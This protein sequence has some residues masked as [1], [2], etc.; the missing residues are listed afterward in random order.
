MQ[1][2]W[3]FK[4]KPTNQQVQLMSSW[5]ITLRKHRNFML[6]ERN[7]GYE[8]NNQDND[9]PIDY[10]WGGYCAVET[11]IEYFSWCPLTCPVLKHG[12][13]PQDL[14][15]ALKKQKDKIV[16]DN[17]SGIQSKITTQLRKTN[18]WFSVL[19]SNVLQ[20]NIAKLDTAFS[21]F[22]KKETGYPNFKPRLDSFEYK[23]KQVKLRRF[24]SSYGYFYLPGI[25]E[26]KFH[27]SRDL[28]EIQQIRT[29]TVTR[30]GGYWFISLLVEIPDTL[31]ETKNLEDVKSVI[32]IDVGV[33]KLVSS[34]DGK[35]FENKRFTTNKRTARRLAIRDRS[36]SRKKDGSNNKR[37][38]Y[39]TLAKQKHKL[40]TKR[41]GYNWQVANEIVNTADLV[42][43]EDL[44]IQGMVKRAKPKHDGKG[45]YKQN[46]AQAKSGLN[47][48]ILDC[49]WSQIFN[50]IAWLALKAGKP[51][52]EVNP[53][54]SSQVC[55]KCGH[56]DKANRKGEK[57]ICLA[58]GFVDHADTKAARE[59]AKRVGL[60][61]PKKIL[62][63]DCGK[64]TSGIPQEEISSR[65]TKKS[66]VEPGNQTTERYIQL[67]LFE[68]FDNIAK[69][70][71]LEN[72]SDVSKESPPL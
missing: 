30:S 66:S 70:G 36:A 13:I 6:N 22:F 15:K 25:G 45:G 64:V 27:N 16:W 3:N 21:K 1:I 26:V 34:S 48:V 32:G 4:L 71:Y 52:I 11:K 55:P 61:F 44:N 38:A 56:T 53:R 5:L 37:K 29:T 41:D 19:D 42:A 51:V 2:R 54:F 40:A 46:G 43:R 10:D 67:N 24:S 39:E 20:R 60:I 65:W 58:C 50:K 17:A 14:S 63:A 57:F 47:K 23:P 49:A 12:V 72:C 69:N 35:F 33:N 31:P 8:T 18:R 7:Q 59:I 62:P 28:T 9:K 68:Y